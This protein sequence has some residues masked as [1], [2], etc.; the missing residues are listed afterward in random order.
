MLLMPMIK[1]STICRE[2]GLQR[3]GLSIPNRQSLIPFCMMVGAC[4]IG[5]A[6]PTQPIPTTYPVHGRVTYEDGTPVTDGLVQFHPDA[7]LS[8]A[9]TGKIQSDGA[10]SL[11]TMRDGLRAEGALPGPNRAIVLVV[12]EN[13]GSKLDPR[14]Q[15]GRAS[16]TT[17]PTPYIV[18]PKDNEINLTIQRQ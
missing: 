13:G 14:L 16:S 10:Y 9:T 6:S 4:L 18:E 11:T 17:F 7:S 8:V 1:I 2:H 12:N 3:G 15:Q 5:C